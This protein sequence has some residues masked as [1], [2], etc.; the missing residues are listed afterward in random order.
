MLDWDAERP[1][2]DCCDLAALFEDNLS[3][4]EAIDD[5]EEGG[6]GGKVI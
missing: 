2:A 1:Q 4:P 3:V 6:G 5:W